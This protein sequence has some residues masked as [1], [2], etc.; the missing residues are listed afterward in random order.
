MKDNSFLHPQRASHERVGAC[1]PPVSEDDEM[2]WPFPEKCLEHKRM[3]CCSWKSI[4]ALLSGGERLGCLSHNLEACLGPDAHQLCG[5]GWTPNLARA[6]RP[7]LCEPRGTMYLP[8]EVVT[9][10]ETVAVPPREQIG[11]A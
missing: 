5:R 10:T 7:G 3:D 6:P 8:P 4:R 9:S 11:A 2:L 1:E